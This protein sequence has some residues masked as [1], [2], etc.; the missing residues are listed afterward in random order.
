VESRDLVSEKPQMVSKQMILN[1]LVV[2]SEFLLKTTVTPSLTVPWKHIALYMIQ[3]Q[4]ERWAAENDG[5]GHS[6][7]SL[8]PGPHILGS[9]Y[10]R[11]KRNIGSMNWCK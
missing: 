5:S 11:L 1:E 10:L 3:I 4:S 8:N 9:L 6:V 2:S 7:R